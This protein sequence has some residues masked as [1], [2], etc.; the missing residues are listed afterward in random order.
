MKDEIITL[1]AGASPIFELR[2]AIPL[3]VTQFGM[4]IYKALILGILGNMVIVI[5]LFVFLKFFSDFLQR[6]WQP[7]DKLMN[8]LYSRFQQNHRSHFDNWKWDFVALTIFVA[9]PLPFTG[10]WS[11]VIAAHILGLSLKKTASAI[12]LGIFISGLIVSGVLYIGIAGI[13]FIF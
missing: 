5:P 2:G 9:V 8:W 7:F 10:A 3:A 13:N 4:P 12:F 1:I 11:G 6:Q